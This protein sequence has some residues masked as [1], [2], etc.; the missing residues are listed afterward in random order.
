[1]NIENLELE[2]KILAEHLSVMDRTTPGYVW[3]SKAAKVC[4]QLFKHIEELDEK[5]EEDPP[6]NNE[7]SCI[8]AAIGNLEDLTY[9]LERLAC[10]IRS[11][12]PK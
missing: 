1:M 10:N 12:Q 4:E 7:L 5:L 11:K 6:L 2:Y 8:N 3:V 9:D